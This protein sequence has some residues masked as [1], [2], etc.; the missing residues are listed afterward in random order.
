M[1]TITV[2]VALLLTSFQ[3]FHITF[4][5]FKQE[6]FPVKS[7]SMIYSE[8]LP[9]LYSSS[10]VKSHQ[11]YPFS[12]IPHTC[13]SNSTTVC[14]NLSFI[15]T[16]NQVWSVSSPTSR[17]LIKPYNSSLN[18]NRFSPFPSGRNQLEVVR[19]KP[20]KDDTGFIYF[21]AKDLGVDELFFAA[22][23]FVEEGKGKK[24]SFRNVK[25]LHHDFSFWKN[26]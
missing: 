20:F 21:T 7:P 13:S 1:S 14:S 11:R 25:R 6:S 24:R 16:S 15:K 9:I 10:P 3:T 18:R 5:D 17:N 22:W 8:K 2:Q 12:S 4:Q 26:H 23:S 19:S